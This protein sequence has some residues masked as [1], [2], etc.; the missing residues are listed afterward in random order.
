MILSFYS[1]ILSGL[2]RGDTPPTNQNQASEAADWEALWPG[3]V[4][5][6]CAFDISIWVSSGCFWVIYVFS[7]HSFI[8]KSYLP[9][10]I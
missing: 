8:P 5:H 6:R 2:L 4:H 1:V 9:M 3:S 7:I 10:L